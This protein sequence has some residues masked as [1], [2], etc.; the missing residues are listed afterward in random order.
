MSCAGVADPLPF[1]SEAM[2]I[3]FVLLSL[4]GNIIS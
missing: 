2:L 1:T 3:P 4:V